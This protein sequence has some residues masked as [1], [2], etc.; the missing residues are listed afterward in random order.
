VFDLKSSGSF[1]MFAAT[2]RASSFVS[3]P[4]AVFGG[5]RNDVEKSATAL[6]IWFLHP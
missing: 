3:R 6:K 2:R 4:I 5:K 1:A